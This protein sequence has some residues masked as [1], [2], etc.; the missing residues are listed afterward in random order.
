MKRVPENK[1]RVLHNTAR[2]R[3]YNSIVD[4]MKEPPQRAKDTMARKPYG[5]AEKVVRND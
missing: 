4:G 5:M 2:R 1:K 3:M